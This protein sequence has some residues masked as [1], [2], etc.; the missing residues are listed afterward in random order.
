MKT[1]LKLV[2]LILAALL[3]I[4]SVTL[5]ADNVVSITDVEVTALE[6]DDYEIKLDVEVKNL[7]VAVAGIDVMYYLYTAK[8]FEQPTAKINMNPTGKYKEYTLLAADSLKT[9]SSGKASFDFIVTIADVTDVCYLSVADATGKIVHLEGVK[10]PGEVKTLTITRNSTPLSNIEVEVGSIYQLDVA[11]ADFYGNDLAPSDITWIAKKNGSVISSVY[12]N[13]SNKLI[14]S[15]NDS[16]LPGSIVTLVCSCGGMEKTIEITVKAKSINP[17]AL[18]GGGG[19]GAPA[20]EK[21][22][23]GTSSTFAE[24]PQDYTDKTE[25]KVVTF[26]D[27]PKTAWY[28]N[29]ISSLFIK[30]IVNGDADGNIRP[31]S[32]ITREEL[33]SILV[34]VLDL[35]A[36]T[37]AILNDSTVSNW[38]VNEVCVAVAYGIINGDENGK[39]NG[40]E[41]CTRQDAAVLL[42]RAF[43]IAENEKEVFYTDDS[44]IADYA[45]EF[46]KA[47]SGNGY[48]NGYEDGTFRPENNITRAELFAIINRIIGN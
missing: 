3:I 39:L 11:A 1:K 41:Y 13:T 48:I 43:D 21:A 37:D 12:V 30:G 23:S 28:Y 2:P 47:L 42:G 24:S 10:L 29:D 35:K 8:P 7:D 27:V 44:I 25:D 32:N 19:G 17:P 20:G 33:V 18:G 5:A 46:V 4:P 9:N 16:S 14:I 40:I 38:A 22:L 34:R 15:D 6:N 26:L 36:D 45:Q 31:E